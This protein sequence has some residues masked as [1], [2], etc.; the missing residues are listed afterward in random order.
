MVKRWKTMRR[1][2]RP[3]RRSWPP[4]LS[5]PDASGSGRSRPDGADVAPTDPQKR[6]RPAE[7][8][9][10]VDRVIVTGTSIR[11]V[12][13]TGSNLISVSRDDIETIGA[14]NTPDLLASVPQLNSFNT[15][16]QASMRRVRFVCAG[17][18]RPA[19]KRDAAADEWSPPGRG[20]CE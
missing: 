9:E 4:V 8:A 12:P 1:I 20:G 13:P 6:R 10:A 15:A 2:A 3:A 18:A 5:R 17:H 7:T 19:G 14:A 16:P 11:G